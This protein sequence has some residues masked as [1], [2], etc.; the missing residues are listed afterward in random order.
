V[1]GSFAATLYGK[2]PGSLE[3]GNQP[4]YF[5]LCFN[6]LALHW[7]NVPFAAPVNSFFRAVLV[8]V[9]NQKRK[10]NETKQKKEIRRKRKW[11]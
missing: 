1:L 5:T 10:E 6:T 3:P 11:I 7:S 9:L 8:T 4:S 2:A